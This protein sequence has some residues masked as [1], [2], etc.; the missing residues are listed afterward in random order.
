MATELG[1]LTFDWHFGIDNEYLKVTIEALIESF[2]Q[3]FMPPFDASVQ[4]QDASLFA[5]AELLQFNLPLGMLLKPSVGGASIGDSV[6]YVIDKLSPIMT[7]YGFIMPIIEVIIAIIEVLCALINPIALKR[8]LKKLLTIAIPKLL[9]LIPFFAG[10]IIIISIIKLILAI[11]IFIMTVVIPMLEL[12]K[13]N[14]KLVLEALESL[15]DGDNLAQDRVDAGKEKIEAMIV[16]LINQLG[17]L[18]TLIPV[19]NLITSMLSIDFSFPCKKDCCSDDVCPDI[20]KNPPSGSG[21]LWLDTSVEDINMQTIEY[22][23]LTTDA[24]IININK[25][26]DDFTDSNHKSGGN[27]SPCC[28]AGIE[29]D[30]CPSFSV[31]ITGGGNAEPIKVPLSRIEKLSKDNMAYSLGMGASVVDLM[32]NRDGDNILTTQEINDGALWGSDVDNDG[33]LNWKDADSDGDGISDL[34]EGPGNADGT[35]P[36]Y[37]NPSNNTLYAIYVIGPSELGELLGIINYNIEP[38]YD[39]LLA[40]GVISLGC[41]PEI[42]EAR[43]TAEA[44]FNFSRPSLPAR[45]MDQV[46]EAADSIAK[47]ISDLIAWSRVFPYTN[48]IDQIQQ[49]LADKI[50]AKILEFTGLLRNYISDFINWQNSTLSINKS[51]VR[52]TNGEFATIS[53]VVKDDAGALMLRNVPQNVLPD[54]HIDASLGVIY[55]KRFNA[56][57]G[58]VLFDIKSDIVGDANI[59]CKINSKFISNIINGNE[60]VRTVSVKFV[61]DAILPLRRRT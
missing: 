1:G 49:D 40:N 16:E 39:V 50:G 38:N 60:E 31:S 2:G 4:P 26:N 59:S 11:L 30:S 22:K 15:K 44:A 24:R 29:D 23:I 56:Q 43:E 3:A 41:I 35:R 14:A 13:E 18:K 57:T 46:N 19:I 8:A 27:T 20:I 34:V 47:P 58:A 21:F 5:D 32:R 55:N 9:Q 54:I 6:N 45:F 28:P 37:L 36:N 12:I 7:A 42:A 53:V 51:V 10:V 52:V 25:Y 33:A 17:V 48:D 61:P